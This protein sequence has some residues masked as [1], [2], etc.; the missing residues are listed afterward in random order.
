MKLDLRVP[1]KQPL[2]LT[3]IACGGFVLGS[4]GRMKLV[5]RSR[6]DDSDDDGGD[7]LQLRAVEM[8]LRDILTRAVVGENVTK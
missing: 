8:L 5:A 7:R 4:E 1:G 6:Q 2:R 3:K